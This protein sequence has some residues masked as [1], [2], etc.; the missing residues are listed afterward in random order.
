M[1]S[2]R[3]T[4]AA[5]NDG[6]R[7]LHEDIQA[8]DQRVK[9]SSGA[10]MALQREQ[11]ARFRRMAE[12]RLD[13]V[14]SGELATGLELADQRAA[15]LIRQRGQKLGVVNRRIN[16]NRKEQVAL[17][18]RRS[19]AN[20]AV[21][22][23]TAAL[24]S[25]EARVQEKL[26]EDPRYQAQLEK[27][28]EAETTAEHAREKTRQAQATRAEKG[29]PYEN[30]PLFSYLWR[31]KY[32]TSG[33]SA[34]PLSRYLDDWVA[35]LCRYEAARANYATLLAI[36]ERL[37]EHASRLRQRADE[38]FIGLTRIEVEAAEADG[39]PPL[40]EALDEAQEALDAI[41]RDIEGA[42]NDLH[43][44]ER[45]RSRYVSGEDEEFREAIDTISSAFEREKV[46]GLYEY[47]RATATPED[48]VI[49]QEIDEARDQLRS[50]GEIL[51]D[52]RRM[53]ER[54][55]ERLQELEGVRRRFKQQRFDG[56]QSEFR[57]E[58][59]LG[60]ALA[61]FLAG[62]ATSGELWRAIE[63]SQRYRR[64]ESDPAFGSGGFRPRPGSW[65]TPFP[66][67]GGMR[68]RF[69][70]R[71]GGIGGGF[72]GRGGGFRTGGGF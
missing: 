55:S 63:S 70:R 68:G 65:R 4:L 53:R 42:E 15:E 6:L 3:Q 56:I 64:I 39:V 14:I 37:G 26:Q 22:Q 40:K 52:R 35:G 32:G 67:C 18:T 20:L 23:A 7:S 34:G 2:G 36:P 61:Q 33:Y 69:R 8:M 49:V 16:A 10:L 71:G 45:Q 58:A 21:E 31:R 57:N 41:D 5:I 72:G 19:E 62:N 43:E 48:D 54:Q 17:E 24:D 12:I 38:E 30:D 27:T 47:A 1:Q 60:M 50:A 44:L 28:R 25:A 11:S 51:A 9:E 66:H 29:R 13:H 46:L 59:L